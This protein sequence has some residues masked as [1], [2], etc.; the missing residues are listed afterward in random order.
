MADTKIS[1]MTTASTLDGGEI[2]PLVQ[3]GANKQ[4]T[5]SNIL[6]QGL[7]ATVVTEVTTAQLNT[8]NMQT[9]GLTGY[10]Y[11]N[12]SSG[13]VTASTTIPVSAV[14][15]Q[16]GV[17]QNN[18]TLTNTTPGTGMA[19]H[20][21]TTDISG[22]GVEVANDL[23]GNPTKVTITQAGVYNFQFS[24][25]L[26]KNGGGGTAIDV[27]IWARVDGVD[28]PETNTRITLQGA[29]LY[30]VAAWNLMLNITAGQYFQLMWGSTDV[31]A[32]VTYIT[33][34]TIGPIV[35]AVILTV[36]RVG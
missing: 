21:D 18:V 12:G 24:A 29:N 8:I 28:V 36:N 19:M 4:N 20:F 34:P 7:Q 5:V 25:Q 13:N 1:A 22:H 9:D 31:H 15:N 6:D 3:S 17:F 33:S 26:N 14:S 23:A 35:P 16:Y 11:G 10:L 2:M 27:Y 32:E 30:T